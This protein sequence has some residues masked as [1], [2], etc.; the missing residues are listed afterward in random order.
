M[1]VT[2][3]SGIQY[4]DVIRFM[5]AP[6]ALGKPESSCRPGLHPAGPLKEKVSAA[7]ILRAAAR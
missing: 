1:D 2:Q 6:R 7:A 5:H 3:G 4:A